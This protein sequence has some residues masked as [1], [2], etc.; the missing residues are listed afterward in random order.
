MA[1]RLD[2]VLA[3]RATTQFVIGSQTGTVTYRPSAISPALM[4]RWGKAG[5]SQAMDDIADATVAY[6]CAAVV[7][8]DIEDDT[9]CVPITPEAVAELPVVL[10][11]AVGEAMKMHAGEAM[12]A[13][14]G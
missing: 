4:S 14:E 1:I 12:S 2:E 7:E 6:I 13:G 5:K 10:L 11:Y 3:D 9:G 8:W